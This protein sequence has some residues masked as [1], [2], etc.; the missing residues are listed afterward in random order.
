MFTLALALSREGGISAGGGW[1][2]GGG[3]LDEASCHCPD[4]AM[5]HEGSDPV[6]RLWQ[7]HA[8]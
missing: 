2:F 7:P 8:G 5:Q 3:S 4:R 1:L 6:F